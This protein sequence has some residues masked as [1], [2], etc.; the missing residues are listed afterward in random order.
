MLRR[1]PK[2]EGGTSSRLRFAPPKQAGKAY[3]GVLSHRLR[4]LSQQRFRALAA[5]N[6]RWRIDRQRPLVYKRTEGAAG[7]GS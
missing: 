1:R 5:K 4:T 6:R 3:D 2:I 7:G